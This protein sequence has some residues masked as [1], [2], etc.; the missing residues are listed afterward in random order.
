MWDKKRVTITGAGGFI[1]SHLTEEM[2]RRGAEVTAFLKN[3]ST[4]N[5]GFIEEFELG[6]KKK[7]NI[8]FGDLNDVESVENAVKDA[9]VVFHLGAEISIPYSYVNPR[10][11]VHTNILG[12]FNVLA[13]CKKYSVKKI[14]LMSSSEVYGTPD[15]VP[16]TEAHALK[17]QSPY[18]ASKIAAE[19][20][21][22]SFNKSYGIPVVIARAFNTY[23]PRQSNRAIIPTIITQALTSNEIS[24]GNLEPA[25]DFNYVSDIVGGLIKL[26]E[27]DNSTGEVVNIG[28]GKE[29][30]IGDLV[31]KITF[32]IKKEY[33]IVHNPEKMRPTKS[34]V[35]RLC[36]DN[37]KMKKIT[38]WESK[39]SLDEGLEKTIEWIKEN[40]H[41]YKTHANY[42]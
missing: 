42:I 23:G 40:L 18:S 9:D 33:K 37:S 39:I 3:N 27:S 12:T 24:V 28:S 1:G 29:V 5:I 21:A 20:L 36:A 17:G 41:L 30:S 16:I 15:S 10:T 13:A 25:R 6:I 14:V 31:K 35:M 8:L 4:G 34:E 32:L 11:F 19:K 7:L 38:G 26:A 22:E 2:V